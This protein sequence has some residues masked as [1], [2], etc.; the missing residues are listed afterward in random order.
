MGEYHSLE[1]MQNFI[2]KI[3][4][5]Y[6]LRYPSYE[7]N[8]ILHCCGQEDKYVSNEM[9]KNNQYVNDILEENSDIREL[10]WDEFYNAHAFISS[11]S[12]EEKVYF[13]KPNYA[14][15]IYLD[16]NIRMFRAHLHVTKNGIVDSAEYVSDYTNGVI[17]NFE[18]EGIH[19]R[20]V[21]DVFKKK[22]ITLPPNN[23]LEK[24]IKNAD[25]RIYQKEEMLNCAM[26]RIIERG[27]NRIGPR[28]AYL[29]AK[30][31]NRNI[32]IPM[33]YAIDR[34]DPG[35]R[36][37]INQYIKDGGSKNLE[38]YLDYFS[39][40]NVNDKIE[41]ISLQ[42]LISSERYTPEENELHQRLVNIL[43]SQ[44]NQDEA[45]KEEIKKLRLERKLEKSRMN[46]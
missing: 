1:K 12:S 40:I 44:T 43:S 36:L 21:A 17:K 35:L 28:R 31:F 23:D 39:K 22:G 26:Y 13:S 18:I 9:F 29:F 16:P 30:E 19:I 11:L 4:I 37:F 20:K 7:V 15:V 2:E 25:K 27:G 45:R 5:W 46:K 32:D 14:D 34:T 10:D 42:E 38:C 3:A 6:E 41:I 33:M 24:A 8:R